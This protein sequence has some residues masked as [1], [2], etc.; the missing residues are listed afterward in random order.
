MKKISILSIMLVIMVSANLKGQSTFLLPY[1]G[2][3]QTYTATVTDPGNNNPVRWYV[4]TNTDGSVRAVHG[5]DYTFVT[6]GYNATNNQLEGTGVY[7]VDIRWGAGL[8]IGT[9][10]YVFLEVD[11]DVTHCTNR[12]A[13]QVTITA[14]FNAIVADVSGS[15]SPG[16]VDPATVPP[17]SCPGNVI[18]PV[19]NGTGHTNIGYSE[20]VFRVN[21][22]FSLLAW[23]FEYRVTEKT[24]RPITV[25]NVRVVNA[26]GTQVYS[27]TNTTG[28][29]NL[30][31]SEDYALV[32][33][34]ITNQQGVV[35]DINMD[36]ITANSNTKDADNIPDSVSADNNAD[37]TIEP[38]PA[39]TGFGGN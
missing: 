12:M 27:G 36:L 9:N 15:A 16:S 38:M 32:Y 6:A 4:A 8:A 34:R 23:Q 2:A 14:N 28:I 3:T 24:S 19:W 30:A 25:Q 17:A 11:D 33:V 22:Q 13:L 29:I 26:S 18:N 39:I 1:R 10:Y 21:R 20:L 31:G 37:H 35:L 7:S 5:T